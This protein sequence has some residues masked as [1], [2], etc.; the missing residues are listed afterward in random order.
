VQKKTQRLGTGGKDLGRRCGTILGTQFIK[1]D[2]RR[3]ELVRGAESLSVGE[4][5]LKAVAKKEN[6][7]KIKNEAKEKSV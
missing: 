4:A 7:N 3:K 1:G 5:Y 6:K 2:N